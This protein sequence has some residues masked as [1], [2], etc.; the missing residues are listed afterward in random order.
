A[1]VRGL[2]DAGL[3]TS[4][5]TV[6]LVVALTDVGQEIADGTFAFDPADEDVH[7]A[8]E[9]GV[10]DRLGDVGARLHA[11]R[12]RNDLVVT[13]L[14][15]WLLDAGRRIAGLMT[16]L[17]RTLRGRGD[18]TRVPAVLRQLDRRRLGPRLRPGVP[19]RRRDL[20]HASLT[21]GG[22]SGAVDRSCVGVGGARRGLHDRLEHDAAEAEPRHGRAR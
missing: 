20:R 10:T 21:A 12:S 15:R 22:G 18:T 2:E 14:R 19:G 9:R 6:A 7:S 13:D 4:D 17:A 16:L 8:I 1:H 3:L 5:E 11:G